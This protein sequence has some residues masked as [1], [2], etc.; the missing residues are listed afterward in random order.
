M[1]SRCHHAIA[2]TDESVD[3]P[4][5]H[6]TTD[7]PDRLV[8][9]TTA[10][11]TTQ[12]TNPPTTLPTSVVANQP[13]QPTDQPAHVQST[14]RRRQ[15]QPPQARA[16]PTTVPPTAPPTMLLPTIQ[17]TSPMCS[18]FKQIIGTDMYTAHFNSNISTR[19][20]VAGA[21]YSTLRY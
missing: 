8:P 10:P 1:M 15:R 4:A 3:H 6:V 20:P 7:Q 12:P 14:S 18:V 17:P 16:P 5:D 11:P 19:P 2:T 13:Q 21:T 9:P